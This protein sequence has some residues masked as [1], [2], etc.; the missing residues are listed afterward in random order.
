MI[1]V[2]ELEGNHYRQKIE[3][4]KLETASEYETVDSLKQVLAR[5]KV[6]V[7]NKE[8]YD[9]IAETINKYPTRSELQRYTM[10]W[11]FLFLPLKGD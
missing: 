3:E 7:R 11:H 4:M 2:N 6:V 8:E 5:E 9:R 10:T 1:E